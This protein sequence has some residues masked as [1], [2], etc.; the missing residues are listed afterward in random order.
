MGLDVGYL[1]T[2]YGDGDGDSCDWNP[3]AL[4]LQVRRWG[5]FHV[6]PVA[7]QQS[8]SDIYQIRWYR[9]RRLLGRLESG[10][11]LV[12]GSRTRRGEVDDEGG[13]IVTSRRCGG[14]CVRVARQP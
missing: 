10:R 6:T 7:V 13:A 14:S 3:S 2:V 9:L 11:L 8:I 5:Y 1:V 12:I 4:A